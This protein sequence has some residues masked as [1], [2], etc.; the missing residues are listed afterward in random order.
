[1]T[2]QT[3]NWTFGNVLTSQDMNYFYDNFTAMANGDSGAPNIVKAAMSSDS[4]EFASEID[5]SDAESTLNCSSGAYQTVP[6]GVV[7]LV[8]SVGTAAVQLYSNG[9]WRHVIN[10]S[11]TF[12]WQ[13]ISDGTNV[14]VGGYSGTNTVV[15][16]E[17][18]Q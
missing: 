16:R 12:G 7:N 9:A 10:M 8:C 11:T 2:W 3:L 18:Y 4:V 17:I 15:Y 14:R 1:M 6:A 13:V 5:N